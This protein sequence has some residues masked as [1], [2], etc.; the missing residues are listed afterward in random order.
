MGHTIADPCEGH[1]DCSPSLLQSLSSGQDQQQVY[2][3]ITETSSSLQWLCGNWCKLPWPS[4]GGI[5]NLAM[6]VLPS[7]VRLL[8]NKLSKAPAFCLNFKFSSSPDLIKNLC[9]SLPSHAL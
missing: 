5:L 6:P 9:M 4:I 2:L 3:P 8:P 1:T 7:L